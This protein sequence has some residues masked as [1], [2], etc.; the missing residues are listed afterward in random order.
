MSF[1]S[2]LYEKSDGIALITLNRPD[3]L[4]ALNDEMIAAWAS[5]LE[6]ARKDSSVYVVIVTGSGKA[7]CSGA[8]LKGGLGLSEIYEDEDNPPASEHISWLRDGVH[9]VPRAVSLLDKPYIAAINGLAIGAG[10]DMASM[11]DIR[12]GSEASRFSTGYLNVGIIPGDGGCFLLPRIIGISKALELIWTG[13]MFDAM[14]ALEYGY[15]SRVVPPEDLI[16]CVYDLA[17]RLCEGPQVAIRLSKRLVYRGLN[18]SME[19][20]FEDAGQAMAIALSTRDAR[21]G[22]TSFIQKKQPRFVGK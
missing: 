10:M 8:D 11:C 6:D 12:I 7:F 1:M 19:E 5:A 15:I 4:N 14:Q 3:R 2:I 20:A 21:E 22:I 13:E 18:A 16:E 17:R 9:K